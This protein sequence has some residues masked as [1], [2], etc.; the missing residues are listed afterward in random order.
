MSNKIK[1]IIEYVA[2]LHKMSTKDILSSS[3]ETPYLLP[4]WQAMYLAYLHTKHSAVTI[5]KIFNRDHTTVLHG[6]CVYS[7]IYNLPRPRDIKFTERQRYKTPRKARKY[8]FIKHPHDLS[9]LED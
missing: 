8:P 6:I 2:K 1:R 5:G 9:E 3:R 7:R 4:R